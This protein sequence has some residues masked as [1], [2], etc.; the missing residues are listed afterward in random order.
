[1]ADLANIEPK[2]FTLKKTDKQYQ[3]IIVGFGKFSNL[4][5]F[6][7]YK[8]LTA[9]FRR[10]IVDEAQEIKNH[11]TTR[12]ERVKSIVADYKWLVSGNYLQIK[13]CN[14]L[15]TPV[16]QKLIKVQQQFNQLVNFI[17]SRFNWDT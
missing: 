7:K 4:V 16:S 6:Q 1:M 11:K 3:L 13:S 8:V 5:A 12:A 2:L 17:N 15:A 14:Q 10:L 9:H